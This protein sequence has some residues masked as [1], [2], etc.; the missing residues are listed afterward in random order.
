MNAGAYIMYQQRFFSKCCTIVLHVVCFCFLHSL[1][2]GSVSCVEQVQVPR[3]QV[4]FAQSVYNYAVDA[5]PTLSVEKQ[6]ALALYYRGRSVLVTG[7]AG[8]IGSELVKNL[9]QQG[10]KVT[11]LDSLVATED[12]RN[13]D[14]VLDKIEFI[15]GDIRDSQTCLKATKDKSVVFHLAAYISVPRSVKNPEICHAVNVKGTVNLLEA[16]RINLVDRFVFSSSCAVYGNIG[17]KCHE[18]ASCK[19]ISPYGVSKLIG[20]RYCQQYAAS[21][22]LKTACLRYFNVFGPK[23]S[24]TSE[25]ASAIAQFCNLMS[26]NM[27]VT[28]FGNGQ[29]TRDYIPVEKVVE[30]NLIFGAQKGINLAGQPYNI[31]TGKSISLLKLI[32][33][34]KNDFT[35]YACKPLFAP[36][37]QGDVLFVD[38]DTSRYFRL[39]Q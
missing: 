26:K 17:V 13:I 4:R 8:F 30:A 28:I 5:M 11:V 22:G 36:P 31:A 20:E 15:K 23:Q 27:S 37:R 25:Y 35:G 7:G 12:T 10:A 19:P 1:T 2:G 3:G 33:L 18:K 6:Q 9:V 21:F 34:L 29:Q 38:A 16:C 39:L 32:N 24:S 14:D